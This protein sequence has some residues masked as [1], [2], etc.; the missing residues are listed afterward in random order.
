MSLTGLLL[1]D[2][3]PLDERNLKYALSGNLCRCTG[4]RSL[5]NCAAVLQQQL[6]D[7][8]TADRVPS[9]VRSGALPDYFLEIP[10]RLRRLSSLRPQ[11]GN[12]SAS[13]IRIAGGTDLYVQRGD[14]LPDAEVEVLA[15]RPN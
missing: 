13:A 6:G 1:S 7:R 4:Y 2:R 3:Q 5:K 14:D 9:L 11:N 15:L 10:E 8:L 12:G